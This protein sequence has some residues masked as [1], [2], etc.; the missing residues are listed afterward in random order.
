MLTVTLSLPPEAEER[1]ESIDV[2]A[3]RVV[4]MPGV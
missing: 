1:F 3:G 2:V 4:C